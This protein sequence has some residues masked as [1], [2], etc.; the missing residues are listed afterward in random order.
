LL[1]LLLRKEGFCRALP[2]LMRSFIT[3]SLEAGRVPA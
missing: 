3:I 1:S 2:H